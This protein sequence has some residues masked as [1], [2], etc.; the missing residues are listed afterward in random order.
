MK[1]FCG[2]LLFVKLILTNWGVSLR[3][4]KQTTAQQVQI[5]RVCAKIPQQLLT[6]LKSLD[7]VKVSSWTKTREEKPAQ[8]A[9]VWGS[10]SFFIWSSFF[11]QKSHDIQKLSDRIKSRE[12]EV[13]LQS[14]RRTT[15]EF[16]FSQTFFEHDFIRPELPATGEKR[17]CCCCRSSC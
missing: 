9:Q 3:Q 17:F 15:A 11:S 5:I 7:L 1:L 4:R 8:W 14:V 16:T 12:T 2:T 10:T 13:L 6:L